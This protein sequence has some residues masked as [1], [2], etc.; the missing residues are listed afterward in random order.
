MVLFS[1]FFVCC[2]CVLFG[3][4]ELGVLARPDRQKKKSG[5]RES[6]GKKKKKKKVQQTIYPAANMNMDL[7]ILY[8]AGPISNWTKMGD[9]RNEKDNCGAN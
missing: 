9:V 3:L 6:K 7:L 8:A 5:A 4:D 2:G 1:I